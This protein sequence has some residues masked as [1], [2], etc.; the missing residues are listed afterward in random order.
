MRDRK[1]RKTPKRQQAGKEYSVAVYFNNILATILKYNECG[2]TP[3]ETGEIKQ[4]IEKSA[5]FYIQQLG[6]DIVRIEPVLLEK[7]PNTIPGL[8]VTQDD[9]AKQNNTL[10]VDIDGT[11]NNIQAAFIITHERNSLKIESSDNSWTVVNNWTKSLK[12][13]V[14]QS[15]SLKNQRS[16]SL[17]TLTQKPKQT[18]LLPSVAKTILSIGDTLFLGGPLVNAVASRLATTNSTPSP[19]IDTKLLKNLKLSMRIAWGVTLLSAAT[20]TVTTM[21]V[22]SL[23]PA[24]PLFIG[25]AVITLLLAPPLVSLTLGV[26]SGYIN[27]Q[28][29][30]TKS[31]QSSKVY[32][33]NQAASLTGTTA[34]YSQ[35]TPSSPTAPPLPSSKKISPTNNNHTIQPQYTN[36]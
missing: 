12:T 2:H 32:N 31:S 18:K 14:E 15:Q 6:S 17:Q 33:N 16:N 27:T 8:K 3:R 30:S 24:T 35:I 5:L 10:R 23:L 13:L 34:Q 26:F 19:S 36:G 11:H 20:A 29:S 1:S 28:F 21:C 25:L 7:I 4:A 9:T 22:L